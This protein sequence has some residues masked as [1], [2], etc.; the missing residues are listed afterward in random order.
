MATLKELVNTLGLEVLTN[1]DALDTDVTTGYASDMLSDVMANAPEGSIWVTMQIHQNG[2]AVA[3]LRSLSAILLVNNRRPD[4]ATIGKAQEEGV[5]ILG[6]DKSAFSI[7]G[8]L[9]ELG[10]RG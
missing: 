3:V 10:I 5:V 8:R 6:S 1:P 7:V 2:V 9:Y 4:Q